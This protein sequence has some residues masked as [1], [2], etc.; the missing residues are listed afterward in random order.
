MRLAQVK[1]VAAGKTI[2]V[3]EMR[4]NLHLLMEAPTILFTFPEEKPP[5]LV[6]ILSR[7]PAGLTIG[8][9]D[10]AWL[11]GRI[12]DRFPLRSQATHPQALWTLHFHNPGL[13]HLFHLHL[14]HTPRKDAYACLSCRDGLLFVY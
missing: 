13:F 6:P 2:V 5:R 3:H 14:D 9:A 12:S 7:D 1:P 8:G 10:F 11:I 4:R